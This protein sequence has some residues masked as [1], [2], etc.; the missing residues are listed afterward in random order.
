[1]SANSSSSSNTTGMLAITGGLGVSENISTRNGYIYA[2]SLYGTIQTTSQPNI[3]TIGTLGS[4]SV[5]G[6]LSVGGT[7][8]A[9]SFSPSSLNIS[10]TGTL[11]FN[12]DST[13]AYLST[14]A[15]AGSFGLDL[16]DNIA[17]STYATLTMRSNER[18]SGLLQQWA[19]YGTWYGG[20]ATEGTPLQ[21]RFVSGGATNS[22]WTFQT[23]YPGGNS[24]TN[25]NIVFAVA[26]GA[27]QMITLSNYVN[28]LHLYDT[29][30]TTS[31]S[32]N[33]IIGKSTLIKDKV[34]ISTTSVAGDGLLNILDGTVGSTQVNIRIGNTLSSNN[35][36][37]M[38]WIP[39]GNSNSDPRELW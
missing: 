19:T 14:S 25:G 2:S 13:Q 1:M 38:I 21:L 20:Q 39:I 30:T 23:T 36:I 17:S 32:Q 35:C 9:A 18:Y 26:N 5:S 10:S 34:T 29:A 37:T 16:I 28:Q 12:T 11:T 31:Y 24:T 3:T 7:L 4:L 8:T 15:V 33:I 22:G 27:R 6:G